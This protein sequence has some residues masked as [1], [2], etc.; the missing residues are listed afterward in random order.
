M[1]DKPSS[2]QED[3]EAELL[4]KEASD[5]LQQERLDNLWKEWGSTIIGVALML[6]F[7]TMMGV[8]WKNWRADVNTDQT[9][10]LIESQD[11]GTVGLDIAKENG[12]SGSHK[13]LMN[14]ITAADLITNADTNTQKIIS[15]M[16]SDAEDAGLPD[17][18]EAI[19]S[20]TK[21]RVQSDIEEALEEKIKIADEMIE[22][23]GEKNNPYAPAILVE[24]ATLYGENGNKE[25]ALEILKAAQFHEITDKNTAL[26]GLIK[27]LIHLYTL[28][29]ETVTGE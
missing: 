3:T 10:T 5:A 25:K 9:T 18:Y 13:G 27:K 11:K 15:N 22:L 7:G 23:A 24:A 8:G 28:E 20:W 6:V 12:I 14:I 26:S 4:L 19:A 29:T 2:P 17:Q 16:M 1:A 21:L